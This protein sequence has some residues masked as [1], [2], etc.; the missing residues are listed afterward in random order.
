[1]RACEKT[2][3]I[4]TFQI[5]IEMPPTDTN[6]TV[7]AKDKT[8]APPTSCENGNV[9]FKKKNLLLRCVKMLRFNRD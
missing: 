9:P 3:T 4:A 1:M 6:L 8:R 2:T 5:A 7:G